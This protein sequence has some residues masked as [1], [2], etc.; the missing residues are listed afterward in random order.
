MVTVMLCME[1][2]LKAKVDVN[3][4]FEKEATAIYIACLNGHSHVVSTLL[5]FGADSNLKKS[6]GWTPLKVACQN[7]HGDVVELLLK[8][9]L[10]NGR[11]AIYIACENDHSGIVS[12]LLKFA[13]DTNLKRSSGW[14]PLMVACRN[15]TVMLWNYC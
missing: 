2:L 8:A 11:T 5:Q 10:E 12:T 15:V 4:R 6:D 14:T 13:A 3:A 1:L 9:H 7:G